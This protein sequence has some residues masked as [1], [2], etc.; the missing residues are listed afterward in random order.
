MSRILRYEVPVDDQ[1]HTVSGCST[2]LH[3]DCREIDVVEFWAW[4][5][6]PPDRAIR[7]FR[8][9]GTGHPIDSDAWYAGTALTPGRR[10]V[11]H[12]MARTP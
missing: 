10:L 3:V 5:L 12:L 7:E 8:V 1:W 11:W 2:P 9:F 4:E 6:Q